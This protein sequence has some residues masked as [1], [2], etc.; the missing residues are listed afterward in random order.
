MDEKAFY[1]QFAFGAY[2]YA[3]LTGSTLNYVPGFT[4]VAVSQ[5]TDSGFNGFAAFNP[6]DC[7]LVTANAGTDG[8]KDVLADITLAVGNGNVQVRDC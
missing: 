6:S 2:D 8:F 7:R 4:V 1:S 3:L 5:N